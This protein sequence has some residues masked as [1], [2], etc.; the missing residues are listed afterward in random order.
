M[1]RGTRTVLGTTG[2]AC[3]ACCI[4][5]IVAVLGTI[6]VATIAGVAIVGIGGFALALPA[7]A[8]AIRQRRRQRCGSA[9]A[10][11]TPV[12]APTVRSRR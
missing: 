6:G 5:P 3:A 1:N 4:G 10:G 2:L 11:A 7:A 9:T 12:A 8:G